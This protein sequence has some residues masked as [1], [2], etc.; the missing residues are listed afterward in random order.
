MSHTTLGVK[1]DTITKQRL[2]SAAERIDRSPHWLLKHAVLE[3]ISRVESGAD[4]PDLLNASVLELDRQRNSL[5]LRKK[6][7]DCL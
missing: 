4:I 6:K 1:V 7:T 5:M 3:W 2:K